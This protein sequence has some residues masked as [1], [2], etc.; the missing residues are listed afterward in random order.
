MKEW[1]NNDAN[2]ACKHLGYAGGVAYLHIMK[3]RRPLLLHTV[4]CRG[5]ETRLDECP[6]GEYPDLTN[7][8]F[9][10]NDAGVLCYND[11]GK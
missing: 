5:T 1:D 11:T 2:V 3:N 4:R 10:S 6:V 8:N 7:C 9:N